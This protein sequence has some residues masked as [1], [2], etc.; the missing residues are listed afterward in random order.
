MTVT[1]EWDAMSPSAGPCPSCGARGCGAEWP[2]EPAR[3][4]LREAFLREADDQDENAAKAFLVATALDVTLAWV[5][6]T[7]V[8]YLSTDNYDVSCLIDRVREPGLS[9][10]ERLE[11]LDYVL[12]AD[13]RQVSGLLEMPE[14]PGRWKDLRDRCD[15]FLYEQEASAFDG[16]SEAD[17]AE[18]A[19]MAVK[20]MAHINNMV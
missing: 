6:R 19:R 5:L 9:T 12:D 11:H 7:A 1:E 16:L 10:K 2:P 20:V 4:L 14:F 8:D 18:T 15:R 13:L 3:L 17:L